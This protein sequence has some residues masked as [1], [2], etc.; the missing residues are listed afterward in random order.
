M[1]ATTLSPK[2]DLIGLI[3]SLP[4][5][6]TYEEI[7]QEIVNARMVNRGLADVDA[8]RAITDEEMRRTVDSWD[9]E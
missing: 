9:E 1:A 2:E 7:L 3:E 4:E 5:D 6:S 8:G